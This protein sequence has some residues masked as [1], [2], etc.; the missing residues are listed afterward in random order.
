MSTLIKPDNLVA[1]PT[2]LS[3]LSVECIGYISEYVADA[4]CIYRLMVSSKTLKTKIKA[5]SPNIKFDLSSESQKS[6]IRVAEF[7]GLNRIKK[8]KLI[9]RGNFIWSEQFIGKFVSLAEVEISSV[10][11]LNFL[12]LIPNLKILSAYGVTFV[13][14]Y[15]ECQL[16]PKLESFTIFHTGNITE[17]FW[18]HLPKLTKLICNNMSDSLLITNTPNL[19]DLEINNG[20]NFTITQHA[21]AN[22]KSLTLSRGLTGVALDWMTQL[23]SITINSPTEEGLNLLSQKHA[24][25]LTKLS[26]RNFYGPKNALSLEKIWFYVAKFTKLN[27]LSLVDPN[28]NRDSFIWFDHIK[29]MPLKHLVLDMATGSTGHQHLLALQSLEYLHIY[30]LSKEFHAFASEL[31]L[32]E[33]VLKIFYEDQWNSLYSYVTVPKI[34]ILVDWWDS[35]HVTAFEKFL[36]YAESVHPKL[37]SAIGSHNIQRHF[38]SL[39]LCNSNEMSASPVINRFVQYSKLGLITFKANISEVKISTTVSKPKVNQNQSQA[40]DKSIMSSFFPFVMGVIAATVIF[41][42]IKK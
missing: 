23:K 1:S 9:V 22:I 37:N 27:E 35:S 15:Q 18:L 41:L 26:V 42:V 14:Q 13:N 19:T 10:L 24:N 12:A 32:K 11:K 20:A 39:E 4:R 29:H 16:L 30:H 17:N 38:N 5:I 25:T 8:I 2:K 21:V 36:R 33:I 7:I 34:K 31:P 28:S 6:S 3:D 40:H